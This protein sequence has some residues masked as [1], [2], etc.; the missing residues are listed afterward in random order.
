[1]RVA[2][3]GAGIAGLTAGRALAAAGAAVELFDKR[4]GRGG[5]V[6]T[7]RRENGAFDH[8]ARRFS[9]RSAACRFSA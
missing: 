4:R 2:I 6:S 1:V 9:A 3:V 8:G 5:H 7:R